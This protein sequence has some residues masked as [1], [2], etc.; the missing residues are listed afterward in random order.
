MAFS[1]RQKAEILVVGKCDPDGPSE[2]TKMNRF[3][4]FNFRRLLSLIMALTL[5]SFPAFALFAND[6]ETVERKTLRLDSAGRLD[7]L[8]I[9]TDVPRTFA[10]AADQ[11]G[12]KNERGK[13]V[14][15]GA[16]TVP[17]LVYDQ[18]LYLQTQKIGRQWGISNSDNL[19]PYG[20]ING[21]TVMWGPSDVS[22]ALYFLGDGWIHISGAVG[23]MGYG[24]FGNHNRPFNTAVEM[25][26][27]F[28]CSTIF[29]Q[30]LKRVFGRED[31]G[32]QSYPG[33]AWRPFPSQDDYDHEKTRH[34][35]FPSGH[36]MTTTV[37]FTVLRGNFPEYDDYLF[38]IQVAYTGALAFGM[39]NNGIH[40]FG[41]YPLGIV[42]GYFFGRSALKMSALKTTEQPTTS[43]KT[44]W[45][46]PIVRPG[47]DSLTGEP[48]TNLS[49]QF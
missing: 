9:F 11:A 41:D 2:M 16:L 37:S 13:W 24:Y 34:D 14:L 21:F 22:S 32:V 26:N 4:L 19:K 35:A 6:Q 3:D 1:G 46:Q 31:P 28:L 7:F 36:V 47:I 40:W 12:L 15:V 23:L 25:L 27:G 38:P 5:F 45:L 49:W 17:L 42:L 30:A 44:A 8:Q 18:D 29:E 10:N 39:T 43:P 20:N 33:G 48:I